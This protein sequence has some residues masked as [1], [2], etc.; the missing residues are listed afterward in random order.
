MA[1]GFTGKIL[2]VDLT[3]NKHW[4]EEP[5]ED[6]Y[7]KIMGGRGLVAHYLLTLVPRGAD[8]L[9]PEN[10][11]VFAPGVVTG[12][13]FSGQGRNG[14]GAKS[15][16][17][18]GFGNAEAGGFWG[19]ECKRA[20]YDAVVVRGKAAKP[21]Y[22]WIHEGAVEIRDAKNVW[23][24]GIGDAQD[25]MREEV[26]DKGARTVLIGQAG[27]NLVR[28][29][30]VVNDITHFA[31]RT[32][33][34]AVMGS[35]NFKGIITKAKG[36]LPVA[37]AKPGQELGKWMTQ[38]LNLTWN[39]HDVGTAGG[40]RGLSLAG[41]LP[42]FNFQEGSFEGNEKITGETMRDTILVKRDTCYACAVRCKRVVE[43]TEPEDLKVDPKYGGPE[44][45]SLGALGSN[46]GI[47]DLKVLAKANELTAI[48]G[49]D[50]ISCGMAISWA[51]ECT[52]KGL[53][54][55]A[56]LGG[57]QCR[58]GHSEDLLNAIHAIAFRR[59]KLGN[60]LAEG[61]KRA[62]DQIGRGTDE[63]ALHV[64]GQELPMHEPRIKHALGMGYTVSPTGAC[65]M[66]NM[67]DTAYTA[68]NPGFARIREF[69][70][71]QPI[72]VHG[73][74][75]NKLDLFVHHS[76]WRHFLDSVGLCHFLP[77]SP[78]QVNAVVSGM[79]GWDTDIWELLGTGRRAATM[80]R[81]FNIREGFTDKDDALP[82]R[83]YQEFRNHNSSTGK[84]LVE[85][86]V[87]AARVGY[88]KAMGWDEHGVPTRETLE[89]LGL[90]E[91]AGALA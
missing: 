18:G 21:S 59:G 55:A 20:G 7:R 5:S 51:M 32:G 85:S 17:T 47:D 77:Y 23:G 31:G 37:D 3:A 34:G 63:Y 26:G 13:S 24:L 60:L 76:T 33:V 91:Y 29:A 80:A 50:T 42:T 43:V 27:E 4:V 41:G 61:V 79:T 81:L 44:Y 64:K 12:A 82:K 9:S 52:E 16:L 25:K 39:F 75:E 11:V 90:T 48:Y 36:A 28:Y 46:C 67:H 84:P 1:N 87:D 73:F 49:L 68:D 2:H 38:N 6:F 72:S 40:L 15:P 19:A 45:E 57:E 89:E 62:S 83:F 78:S 22:L 10:V 88:Y 54:S 70:N 30:C 66:H 35:K 69:K 56:D 8:A 65:H 14:V 71:F 86:E 58:F 74:D 53:L